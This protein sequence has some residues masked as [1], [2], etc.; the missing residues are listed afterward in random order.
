M[1]SGKDT[2]SARCPE[3][4]TPGA[5]GGL[6]KRAGGNAGT[7]PEVYLTVEDHD[8]ARRLWTFTL[9]TTRRAE[10]HPSSTGLAVHVLL[11]MA[12]QA[13][14][15]QRP[16]EA[17]RFTQL[18]SATAANRTHPV[19]M[20]TQGN[21]SAVLGWCRAALGEVEPCRRA[22]GQALDEYVGADRA[23]IPPGAHAPFTDAKIAA[24]Q[25]YTQ[26]LLSQS[27]PEFAPA[28]IERLTSATNAYG[29]AYERAR[30]VNLPLLAIV[31]FRAGELDSAVT[32][33]YEA[34]TA[35]SGLASTR[36]YARLRVMDTAAAPFTRTPEV[37]ELREHV[38]TALAA[39]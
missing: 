28:A 27:N 35:V 21:T 22:M 1:T 2:W 24:Q 29:A 6:G 8:A 18:G 20:L 23:T 34:V 33:G 17:L 5:G 32:T 36:G 26:Y 37:A 14:Y 10:E 12:N 25:G 31:C 4:G 3:R 38:R 7:A 39:A 30:A 16:R 11:D 19:S 9:D 13:L 15:L